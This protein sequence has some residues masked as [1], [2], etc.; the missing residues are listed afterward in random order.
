MLVCCTCRNECFE[1]HPFGTQQPG[2]TLWNQTGQSRSSV[3][4]RPIGPI[5][6]TGVKKHPADRSVSAA[7]V[8]KK[9]RKKK[10]AKKKK[11]QKNPKTLKNEAM[12]NGV[13]PAFAAMLT[14]APLSKSTLVI[15]MEPCCAAINKGVNT[16]CADLLTSMSGR[17]WSAAAMRGVMPSPVLARPTSTRRSQHGFWRCMAWPGCL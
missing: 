12:K 15:F 17:F 13:S 4:I 11:I 2:T 3:C 9:K 7:R 6:P 5:R 1:I 10:K 14:S 8:N 16:S